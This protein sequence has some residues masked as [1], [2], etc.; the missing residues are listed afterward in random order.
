MESFYAFD[1]PMQHFSVPSPPVLASFTSLCFK[2]LQPEQCLCAWGCNPQSRSPDNYECRRTL[3]G[4]KWYYSFKAEVS[5]NALEDYLTIC[6]HYL[7]APPLL[8]SVFTSL[9][10][11]ILIILSAITLLVSYLC[12][13]HSDT[14]RKW[15]IKLKAGCRDQYDND[16]V[17]QMWRHKYAAIVKVCGEAQHVTLFLQQ[18]QHADSLIIRLTCHFVLHH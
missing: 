8:S 6:Q 18:Q 5:L 14:R 17:V 7:T 15:F 11:S 1:M 13:N 9:S 4:L 10:L 12:A 2:L 16:T 3:A